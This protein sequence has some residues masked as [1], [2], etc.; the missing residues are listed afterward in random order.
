MAFLFSSVPLIIT[1]EVN[2]EK[3]KD[4]T[5]W[6]YPDYHHLRLNMRY[7]YLLQ[8]IFSV[9]VNYLISN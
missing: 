7:I 1:V 3:I 2:Q 9:I 8:Y 5:G 4:Y 6:L